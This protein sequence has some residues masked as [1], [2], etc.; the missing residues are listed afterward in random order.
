[1]FSEALPKAPEETM[2]LHK[3]NWHAVNHSFNLDF[4]LGKST[5]PG[6]DY[7]WW[8]DIKHSAHALNA[9]GSPVLPAL[10]DPKTV[11]VAL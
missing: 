3:T 11:E 9:L 6:K 4:S 5:N 2:M 7:P 8:L 10:A 1:M